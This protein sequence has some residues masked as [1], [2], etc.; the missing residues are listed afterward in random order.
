MNHCTITLQGTFEQFNYLRSPINFEKLWNNINLQLFNKEQKILFI[1]PVSILSIVSLQTS[2]NLIYGLRSIYCD[3][4]QL[5]DFKFDILDVPEYLNIKL[6]PLKFIDMLEYTWS[7]M[8]KKMAQSDNPITGF[9][10]NELKEL[11]QIIEYM[12]ERT[13]L[14]P[15]YCLKQQIKFFSTIQEYD[16]SHNKNFCSIFPDMIEYYQLCKRVYNES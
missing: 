13:E 11:E 2:I 14:D 3:N 6:L 16:L 5:V 12:Q 15:E 10:P 1:L 4:T 8:L 7:F 9:S